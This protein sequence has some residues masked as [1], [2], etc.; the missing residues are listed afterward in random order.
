[1]SELLLMILFYLKSGASRVINFQLSNVLI[2][3]EVGFFV[4][5]LYYEYVVI[6]LHFSKSVSTVVALQR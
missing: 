1:M 4:K 6:S 5:T 2:S 3:V